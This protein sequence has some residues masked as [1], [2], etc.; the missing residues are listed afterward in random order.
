MGVGLLFLDQPLNR[1]PTEPIRLSR[2]AR[3]VVAS[4]KADASEFARDAAGTD[5]SVLKVELA[6]LLRCS[7]EGDDIAVFAR[8]VVA[9]G[10][11]GS[12]VV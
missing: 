1:E 11:S 10:L 3:S 6:E 4:E 8:E 9:A 12:V 7:C 2:G 5:V